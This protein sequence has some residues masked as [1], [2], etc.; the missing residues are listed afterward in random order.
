MFLLLCLVYFDS[1]VCVFIIH[2]C[3]SA[4]VCVRACSILD[5][6]VSQH[7]TNLSEGHKDKSPDE[8][9]QVAS[10]NKITINLIQDLSM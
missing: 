10:S 3:V 9:A 6:W 2:A 1:M 7:M 8:I 4:C 5:I